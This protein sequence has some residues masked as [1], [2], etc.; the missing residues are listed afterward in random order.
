MKRHGETI[1]CGLLSSLATACLLPVQIHAESNNT[2]RKK[3]RNSHSLSLKRSNRLT[4]SIRQKHSMR[5]YESQG[6]LTSVV[7]QN[8]AEF[9]N[10]YKAEP[11]SLRNS[12]E[13]QTR[14]QITGVSL[15]HNVKQWH[16]DS[17]RISYKT[18]YLL[19][20]NVA[21]LAEEIEPHLGWQP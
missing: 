12:H 17:Q 18:N 10:G 2:G 15:K 21:N 7:C 16:G 8:S 14:F 1:V 6:W 5:L 3:C 9:Q 11:C 19:E 4:G 20:P 13:C